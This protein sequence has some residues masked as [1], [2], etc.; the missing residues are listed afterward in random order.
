MTSD[1]QKVVQ[2]T[3]RAD[4]WRP[5]KGD[6]LRGDYLIGHQIILP[7]WLKLHQN[8]SGDS[9]SKPEIDFPI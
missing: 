7:F 6:Q 5:R 1:G 2:K 8:L 3:G 9:L 4:V